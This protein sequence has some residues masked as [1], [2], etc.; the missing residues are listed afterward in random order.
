M[1]DKN[2]DKQELLEQLFILIAIES[3]RRIIDYL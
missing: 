2:G 1:Y 3:N